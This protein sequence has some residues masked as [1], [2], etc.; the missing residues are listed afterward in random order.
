MSVPSSA[1]GLVKPMA[2][3]GRVIRERERLQG[4][5]KE[6]RIWRAQWLKD[7]VLTERE[8]VPLEQWRSQ[9][10]NP[11]RRAYQFPLDCFRTAITPILVRF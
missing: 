7:Q 2:I 10:R 3:G 4:M 9:L 11:I 5:S 8:P 1:T 6:E